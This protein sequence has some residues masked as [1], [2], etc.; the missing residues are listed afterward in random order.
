MLVLM[1]QRIVF[2]GRNKH[3]M[4][5]QQLLDKIRKIVKEEILNTLKELKEKED[6]EFNDKWEGTNGTTD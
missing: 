4:T 6:K 3:M 2:Q 1:K 5:D